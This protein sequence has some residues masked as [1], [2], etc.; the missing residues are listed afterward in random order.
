MFVN[1]ALG[2]AMI[3]ATVLFHTVG[4]IAL[5]GT[6]NRV[7]AWFRLHRHDFGKTVTMVTTVLGIFS[8]HT[9]EI[10]MWAGL[11]LVTGEFSLFEDALYFSTSTFSTI[12]YGDVTLSPAWRLL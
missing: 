11:F 5:S 1:L 8:L 3:A 2:T 4:L 6:M 9:A 10:W 12:G 7:V